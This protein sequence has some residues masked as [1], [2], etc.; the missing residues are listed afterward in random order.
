MCRALR[1]Y[2][3]RRKMRVSEFWRCFVG[4]WKVLGYVFVWFCCWGFLLEEIFPPEWGGWNVSVCNLKRANWFDVYTN[5]LTSIYL[6]QMVWHLRGFRFVGNFSSWCLVV[7]I[8]IV[9]IIDTN[10]GLL[11]AVP[12]DWNL[13]LILFIIT[14]CFGFGFQLLLAFS[15]IR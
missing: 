13:D 9:W 1:F 7:S 11:V 10:F 4:I 15:Y 12:T 5:Q 2:V 14:L 6:P 3:L 8:V